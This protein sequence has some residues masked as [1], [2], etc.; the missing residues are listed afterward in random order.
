LQTA[1]PRVVAAKTM[2][3]DA[4]Q[5][6]KRK[7]DDFDKDNRNKNKTN[8]NGDMIITQ[9]RTDVGLAQMRKT[10][11]T[12]LVPSSFP[13]PKRKKNEK[14][15]TPRTT[16]KKSNP[17][18]TTITGAETGVNTAAALRELWGCNWAG[19]DDDG[20]DGN[21]QSLAPAFFCDD[22]NNDNNNNNNNNNE[23]E[24]SWGFAT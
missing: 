4:T 2:N 15:I 24:D 3:V 5:K 17:T 18:A 13:S 23:S 14:N 20:D 12:T 16:E 22:D 9:K 10:K 21:G 7:N 11:Q 6:T 1:T 19:G 8:D